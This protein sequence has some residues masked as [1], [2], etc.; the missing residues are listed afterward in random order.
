VINGTT[1]WSD[2]AYISFTLFAA[3]ICSNQASWYSS[4]VIGDS[5]TENNV[6]TLAS[7]SVSSICGGVNLFVSFIG[8]IPGPST[9]YPFNFYDLEGTVPWSAYSCAFLGP[10][11]VGTI[12]DGGDY[13]ISM[14]SVPQQ[15]RTLRPEWSDCLIYN[16]G[17]DDPPKAL[18]QIPVLIDATT[19]HSSTGPSASPGKTP[20]RPGPVSTPAA[21]A[22]ATASDQG[23]SPP[24]SSP[25]SGHPDPSPP[26]SD[27]SHA[28]DPSHASDAQPDADV[29][30]GSEPSA[31][32]PSTTPATTPAGLAQQRRWSVMASSALSSARSRMGVGPSLLVI[33][34]AHSSTFVTLTTGE[35]VGDGSQTVVAFDS[36]AGLLVLSGAGRISRLS[37]P[38][39]VLGVASRTTVLLPAAALVTSGSAAASVEQ[40][41]TAGPQDGAVT[42]ATGAAISGSRGDA[43][44][45]SSTKKNA[46]CEIKMTPKWTVLLVVLVCVVS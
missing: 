21:P 15:V 5:I 36:G 34:P 23:L 6:V 13:Y 3:S 1:Y 4:V 44:P 38:S 19:S 27:P 43:A 40:P 24:Q 26:G 18:N 14:L 39:V 9:V 12:T 30:S 8:G 32:A 37:L 28:L 35:V 22:T 42:S 33:D 11:D 29:P 25:G 17:T 16:L 45:K 31:V 2:S 20:T 7:S 46:G 41:E 10:L